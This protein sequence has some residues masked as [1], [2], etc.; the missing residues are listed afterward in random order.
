MSMITDDFDNHHLRKATG[1]FLLVMQCSCYLTTEL[2][3]V[4][5]RLWRGTKIALSLEWPSSM[6][7]TDFVKSAMIP[8]LRPGFGLSND[9][10]GVM[11]IWASTICPRR[12]ILMTLT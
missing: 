7:A 5:Y 9:G 4:I 1:R 10:E 6:H 8:D 12:G 3:R 2:L 11:S